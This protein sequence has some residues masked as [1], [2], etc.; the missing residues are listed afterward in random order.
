[1][2][3][4][5]LLT[6]SNLVKISVKNMLCAVWPLFVL[7]NH[8]KVV[9][10]SGIGLFSSSIFRDTQSCA[11]YYS[12]PEETPEYL[13]HVGKWDN[14]CVRVDKCPKLYMYC[15]YFKRKMTGSLRNIIELDII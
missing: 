2:K 13:A 7:F 5:A 3:W 9:I 1:M 14:I 12:V 11:A 15:I 6:N 4:F 10:N 8:F